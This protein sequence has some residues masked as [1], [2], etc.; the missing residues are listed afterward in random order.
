M[1]NFLKS[2]SRRSRII[3]WLGLLLSVGALQSCSAIRL[4]YNNLPEV[5]YWWLDNYLDFSDAQTT[6]VRSELT[7]LHA[8][9]RQSELPRTAELLKKWQPMLAKPMPAQQ[10][11]S[12]FDELSNLLAPTLAQAEPAAAALLASLS[13]AQ[14]KHWQERLNKNNAEYKE[15]FGTADQPKAMEKRLKSSTERF[16]NLY[17]ALEDAQLAALKARLLQS[18]YAFDK[19]Y[20]ERLQRQK[21]MLQTVR[22]IAGDKLSSAKAQALLHAYLERS[23]EPASALDP[24]Y[25]ARQRQEACDTFADVHNAASAEQ[26]SRAVKRLAAYERDARELS[27][28]Q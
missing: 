4:A 21:E 16:E 19:S 25:S 3:G 17:G 28:A 20:S 6:R 14:I 7:K 26:R 9:H 18:G 11:C 10:A 12:V 13:E 27:A 5:S 2:E 24:A 15:N 22:K 1:L 23:F 8:W